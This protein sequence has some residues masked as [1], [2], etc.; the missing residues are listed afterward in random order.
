VQ[1]GLSFADAVWNLLNALQK[2]FTISSVGRAQVK[3]RHQTEIT[4]VFHCYAH[5]ILM[6]SQSLTFKQKL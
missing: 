4:A 6:I 5:G 1:I 3:W 2:I